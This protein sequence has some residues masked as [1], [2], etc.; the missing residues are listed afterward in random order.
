MYSDLSGRMDHDRLT[1]PDKPGDSFKFSLT[2]CVPTF[3][4]LSSVMSIE[5]RVLSKA[6]IDTDDLGNMKA[7]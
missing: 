1:R 4:G 2:T 5:S 3:T 7:R 6:R